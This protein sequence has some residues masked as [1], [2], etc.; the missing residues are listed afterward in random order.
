MKCRRSHGSFGRF[1]HLLVCLAVLL[2]TF[3]LPST[4]LELQF[5][6]TV[7]IACI[8]PI[9]G[10]PFVSGWD[11]VSIDLAYLAYERAAACNL[12]KVAMNANPFL[13]PATNV[14]VI[15]GDG[16]FDASQT[17]SLLYDAKDEIYGVVGGFTPQ[18]GVALATGSSTFRIPYITDF[19]NADELTGTYKFPMLNRLLASDE[20]EGLAVANLIY[21]NWS[22]VMVIS[23]GDATAQGIRR[24]FMAQAIEIG[25]SVDLE[26]SV[27]TYDNGNVIPASLAESITAMKEMKNRVIFVNAGIF[28]VTEILTAL[29]DN[30]MLH[31]SYQVIG[32]RYW[33]IGPY[34]DANGVPFELDG[35]IGFT[36][37]PDTNDLEFQAFQFQ[38][39][40]QYIT[41]KASMF[42]IPA[43]ILGLQRY[44]AVT[45]L[46]EA[47]HEAIEL[48]KTVC[49]VTGADDNT[50]MYIVP[51][52][53][54]LNMSHLISYARLTH[55][56]PAFTCGGMKSREMRGTLVNT[57]LRGKE[58]TKFSHPFF[59]NVQ[60]DNIKAKLQIA[61][62]V[63]SSIHI[64]GHSDTTGRE[65]N[66]TTQPI[67]RSGSTLVPA[68]A[69]IL[70]E[71]L[72]SVG[73]TEVYAIF[74]SA[75]VVFLLVSVIMVL[76]YTKSDYAVIRLSSPLLNAFIL[77]GCYLI[78]AYVI[79]TSLTSN[80]SKDSHGS[81]LCVSR[82]SSLSIGMTLFW[83]ALIA[84]MYRVHRIFNSQSLRNSS[85]SMNDMVLIRFIFGL[86]A[87]DVLILFA[88]SMIEHVSL[89]EERVTEP[90]LSESDPG[91]EYV[92][93]EISCTS[94]NSNMWGTL[95]VSYKT[96]LFMCAAYLA[97]QT[98]NVE[99]E[100]LNDTKWVAFSMYNILMVTAIIAPISIYI[101]ENINTRFLLINAA[102]LL[103]VLGILG[104]L[105]VPKL[106]PVFSGKAERYSLTT[107]IATS[108]HFA[109]MQFV[110]PGQTNDEETIYSPVKKLVRS[111][112]YTK[113]LLHEI[114]RLRY[115]MKKAGVTPKTPH[116]H[117]MTVDISAQRMWN[118]M[119]ADQTNSQH[120]LSHLSSF[121]KVVDIPGTPDEGGLNSVSRPRSDIDDSSTRG[122][123]AS[124]SVAQRREMAKQNGN[125]KTRPG[126]SKKNSRI[127]SNR[128]APVN[129]SRRR[130]PSDIRVGDDTTSMAS[131][132][133][134]SPSPV[135]MSNLDVP[136]PPQ[137]PVENHKERAKKRP[138]SN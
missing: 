93:Y 115:E 110:D 52:E 73:N 112:A 84:K 21:E 138:G 65:L 25:L 36:I 104:F 42:N 60:G 71:T 117:H 43:P 95:I 4:S 12:A 106:I 137:S 105:F 114:K 51:P 63:N 45:L 44:T 120:G 61:N 90:Q 82:I 64:I 35:T 1:L 113:E 126:N 80:S 48:E 124:L 37:M 18:T 54:N 123:T 31:K 85:K 76:N 132:P 23:T 46:G 97:Y 130:S 107:G 15:L 101:V 47:I 57:L 39:L 16:L 86:V 53:L 49:N 103:I 96:M 111:V 91:F 8:S 33:M 10:Y 13:L 94:S 68:E 83:G 99:V 34:Y 69:P 78:T 87:I 131:S 121:S 58:S 27:L 56:P 77:S 119:Q 70:V 127:R 74:S 19:V 128:I 100:L 133:P 17:H 129:T 134:G 9:P 81:A 89:E 62:L 88:W 108:M 26:V 29:R 98:K 72:L 24:G 122:G 32:N 67:Y 38:W 136:S 50:V 28:Q 79:I 125:M 92:D 3:P 66:I 116:V 102:L 30:G 6:D 40:M 22:S 59:F 135:G 11:E 75:A 5:E 55:Y 109:P 7:K 118:D 2:V 20:K 14:E 41:D